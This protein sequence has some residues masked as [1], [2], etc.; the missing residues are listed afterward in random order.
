MPIWN[1]RIC[2]PPSLTQIDFTWIRL[3]FLKISTFFWVA[4]T[5][6]MKDNDRVIS[7]ESY[8]SHNIHIYIYISYLAEF[9]LQWGIFQ[10]KL[11]EK[12]KIHILCSIFFFFKSCHLWDNVEKY[13]RARQ[14]TDD[15]IA[16]AH[17]MLDTQGY[18]HTL[19]IRNTYIFSTATFDYEHATLLR[20]TTL[21]VLF[22]NWTVW[23]VLL[24]RVCVSGVAFDCSSYE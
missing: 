4:G 24:L 11:L 8:Q 1:R 16:H 19:R 5:N 12:I 10:A 7:H 21:P 2:L 22:H 6:A 13:S 15:N 20:Y 23:H 3:G 17:C 18:K 9:F 14:A